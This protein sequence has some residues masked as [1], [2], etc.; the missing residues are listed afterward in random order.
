MSAI[1]KITFENKQQTNT[2][3][4][5]PLTQ[6]ITA[7]DINQIK[8][9]VNTSADK[10]NELESTQQRQASDLRS[11]KSDILDISRKANQNEQKIRELETSHPTTSSASI[12][13]SRVNELIIQKVTPIQSVSNEA[14]QKATQNAS[15][16]QNIKGQ[17]TNLQRQPQGATKI[18]TFKLKKYPTSSLQLT[19]ANYWE[20]FKTSINKKISYPSVS[21]GSTNV[22]IR[23][24]LSLRI[25]NAN[26]D[27]WLS[28]SNL[29][30]FFSPVKGNMMFSNS[31]EN[32]NYHQTVVCYFDNSTSTA[33][34]L[35][36]ALNPESDGI[37]I[38]MQANSLYDGRF[39]KKTIDIEYN[40]AVEYLSYS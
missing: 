14:R 12:N 24:V 21:L 25:K 6:Q 37:A 38:T 23:Y 3:F 11:A 32:E 29:L 26:K 5:V 22:V 31:D 13:E 9:V 7:T 16:I 27:H 39:F 28:A 17:L 30:W 15:D 8:D 40:W 1:K 36:F 35:D 10:I 20:P 18:P 19:E 34:L 33:Y 2:V 4:N